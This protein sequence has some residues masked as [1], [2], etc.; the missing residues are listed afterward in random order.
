MCANL[1]VSLRG[2]DE[3]MLVN[4][5]VRE[6]IWLNVC[7]SACGLGEILLVNVDVREWKWLNVCEATCESMC[8]ACSHA[9]ECGWVQ[10]YV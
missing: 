1:H 2:L 9:C 7:E 10:V 6:W 4:V 3:N 5:D 8:F